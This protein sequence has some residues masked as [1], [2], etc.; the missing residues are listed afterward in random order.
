[1]YTY[2]FTICTRL[3]N[4]II[5][6]T[7]SL[8]SVGPP[9]GLIIIGVAIGGT[10]L[11]TIVLLLGVVLLILLKKWRSHT[12]AIRAYASYD[13]SDRPSALCTAAQSRS[14]SQDNIL[15]ISNA[16][17]TFQARGN[18]YQ[19]LQ[20][21]PSSYT[22]VFGTPSA[23]QQSTFSNSYPQPTYPVSRRPPPSVPTNPVQSEGV[24]RHGQTSFPTSH[25]QSSSKR[26]APP[27]PVH[28][29]PS[30]SQSLNHPPPSGPINK[31]LP[32]EDAT[33]LSDPA[34]ERQRHPP[35]QA[36]VSKPAVAR[37][38]AV[39]PPPKPTAP[40]VANKPVPQKPTPG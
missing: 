6:F 31:P 20:P 3:V 13:R 12:K 17:T 35:P 40:H 37:R 9:L 32:L 18:Y 16:P 7:L 10:V 25:I 15:R 26:A 5:W 30:A 22:S 11:L 39:P 8:L 2:A 36:P 33:P 19:P 27:K 29:S 23:Q 14:I 4:T 38:T 21:Q 28:V 24:Q 1:M 34:G